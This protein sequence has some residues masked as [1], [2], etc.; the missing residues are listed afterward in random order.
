MNPSGPATDSLMMAA[1]ALPQDDSM[2]L[3]GRRAANEL[4]I[5]VREGRRFVLKGLPAELR[6]HREEVARLRK[7]FSLGMRINHPNVAG[8]YGFEDNPVSGPS[9]LMEY[10]DGTTLGEWLAAD[11]VRPPGDRMRIAARIADAL[12]YMHSLGIC[13]R[14]LKPDNIMVTRRGDVKIIDIGLGDSDDYITYK[15]SMATEGYGA[16]EQQAPCVGDSRADVYSLGRVMEMLLPERRHKRLREACLR[17]DPDGRPTMAEVAGRLEAQAAG[18]GA[19][20]R[21]VLPGA[22]AV[23]VVAVVIALAA[24]AFF[25]FSAGRPSAVSAAGEAAQDSAAVPRASVGQ[26]VRAAE[27]GEEADAPGPGASSAPAGS[28]ARDNAAQSGAG[29]PAIYDRFISLADEAIEGY[30]CC[31]NPENGGYVKPIDERTSATYA[32]ADRLARELE[33]AGCG[34]AEAE[35]HLADFWTHVAYK[36]NRIDRIDEVIGRPRPRPRE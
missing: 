27:A 24:S 32:L 26:E 12:A 15:M 10:V 2:E 21:R 14:D 29:Y 17:E 13:H 4:W 34:S 7:E 31:Y 18:A 35:R 33:E 22:L 3:L 1:E 25:Y 8:T 36:I 9:I 23:A 5:T 11:A 19:G 28:A 30:G 20:G 16:P 6:G